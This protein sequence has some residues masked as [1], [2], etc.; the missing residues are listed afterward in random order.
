MGF[1]EN[2]KFERERHKLTQQQIADKIGVSV[3]MINRYEM[4]VKLPNI[5]YAVKL[6]EMLD[7]TCEALVNGKQKKKGDMKN[8]RL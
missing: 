6:A 8:E 1:A 4:G 2:F 7:T 5:V 3:V